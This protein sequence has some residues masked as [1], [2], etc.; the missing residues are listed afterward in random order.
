[1][2]SEVHVRDFQSLR[3][4][5]LALGNFT[6]VMGPSNVG[7]T[8]VL[9]AIRMVAQNVS[10]P[11]IVVAHGARA[12]QAT[13]LFDDGKVSAR[14]GPL[15]SLYTLDGDAYPKSGQA[16]PDD[17]AKFLRF[18]QVEG[19][20]LNFAFQ[21]DLPFLLDVSSGVAAK[22]FGDLTN[23]N[24]ILDAARE[25]V[26]RKREVTSV[27]KVRRSDVESLKEKAQEFLGIPAQHK[28]AAA[29]R[30]AYQRAAAAQDRHDRAVA[31]VG[32]VE[33]ADRALDAL[34][35]VPVP[36]LELGHLD[37]E[38]NRLMR[39]ATLIRTVVDTSADESE[40]QIDIGAIEN[41]LA[42]LDAEYHETLKG[43]GQCPVCGAKIK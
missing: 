27:L 43:A 42:S 30:E 6:V 41:Q 23:V 3:R 12:A 19:E 33:A 20:T 9:R 34:E 36:V 18:V 25:A 14:R 17:V 11:K 7:K 8:A 24:R 22:V 4:V 1:V 2:L 5:E 21:H 15:I 16:V 29:A 35:T 28:A 37:D 26:R 31:L 32:V 40:A 38:V 13:L 39:L 10:A